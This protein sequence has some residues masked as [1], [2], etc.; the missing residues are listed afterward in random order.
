M[1]KYKSEAG[2]TIADCKNCGYCE[3]KCP[4]KLKIR[5]ELKRVEKVLTTV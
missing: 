4:Q 2:K 5:D 1:N 3:R